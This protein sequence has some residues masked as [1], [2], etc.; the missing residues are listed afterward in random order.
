VL[1]E[2]IVAAEI[3]SA[4]VVDVPATMVIEDADEVLVR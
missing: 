2:A 1:P 4:V 3:P